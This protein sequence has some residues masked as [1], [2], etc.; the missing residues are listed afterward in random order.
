MTFD[1][2]VMMRVFNRLLREF[3]IGILFG[4]WNVHFT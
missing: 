3:Y 4:I 1:T 2:A